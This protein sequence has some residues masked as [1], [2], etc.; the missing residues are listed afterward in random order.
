MTET[1]MYKQEY[2]NAVLERYKYNSTNDMYSAIGFGAISAGKIVS[3]LLAEYRKEHEELDI[4]EKIEK[5]T[6]EKKT[7]QTKNTSGVI[8]KGIDNCLVK[9]ASCCT[10]VPGDEIVGY[11]TKGRGVSIHRKDCINVKDLIQEE[12]RIIDV[13]WHEAEASS[14]KV[15]I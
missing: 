8:V 9:F 15:D 3:K 1:E 6:T 11:I 5:L 10:P 14:Y 7:P 12:N 4:E 2:I 13:S